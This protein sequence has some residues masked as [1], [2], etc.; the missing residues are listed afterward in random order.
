[1]PRREILGVVHRLA[2]GTEDAFPAAAGTGAIFDS[3]EQLRLI[4][5]NQLF[6]DS[7]PLLEPAGNAGRI[8]RCNASVESLDSGP[9]PRVHV[10][11]MSP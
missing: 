3:R 2:A 7:N 8:R 9:L 4:Q 11:S 10:T 5:L 1:V 6:A